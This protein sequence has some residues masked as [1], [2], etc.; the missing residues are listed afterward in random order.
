MLPLT[1]LCLFPYVGQFDATIH[2]PISHGDFVLGEL[3]RLIIIGDH[4]E[5]FVEM[6]ESVAAVDN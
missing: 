5:T 2:S 1:T 6:H 4:M 3:Q